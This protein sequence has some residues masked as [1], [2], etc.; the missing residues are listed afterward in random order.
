MFP[1]ALETNNK[2]NEEE[3]KEL[4]HQQRNAPTLT[5]I[6]INRDTF[7]LLLRL[8]YFG[9]AMKTL[10]LEKSN[11]PIN[12]KSL[13]CTDIIFRSIFLFLFL[14]LCLFHSTSVFLYIFFI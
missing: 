7:H 10:H 4:A 13:E 1:C 8:S 14:K 5:Q 6:V 3:K 12:K 2:K 9:N 11:E